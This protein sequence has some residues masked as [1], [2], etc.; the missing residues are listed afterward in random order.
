MY[1]YDSAVFRHGAQSF[2][3]GI[4]TLRASG[5]H[6]LHFSHSMLRDDGLHTVIFVARAYCDDNLIGISI[7]FKSLYRSGEDGHAAHVEVLFIDTAHPRGGSGGGDNHAH[8][9]I[10]IHS[11]PT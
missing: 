2:F 9:F 5:Y 10:L 1:Q 4:L 6:S 7:F 11:K 8:F 3:Y